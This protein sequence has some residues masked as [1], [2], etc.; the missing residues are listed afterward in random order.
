MAHYEDPGVKYGLSKR[1]LCIGNKS[2]CGGK[3]GRHYFTQQS[4]TFI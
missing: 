4:Y 1:H 2:E 3:E